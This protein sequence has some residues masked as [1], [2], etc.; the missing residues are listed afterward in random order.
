[1]QRA[2]STA[3]HLRV[4]NAAVLAD[5][6]EQ[7]GSASMTHALDLLLADLRL[8]A[9]LLA[10]CLD[11]G[12]EARARRTGHKLKG[13]MDQ[14][15]IRD[16]DGRATKLSSRYDLYW[17]TECTS[18]FALCQTAIDETRKLQKTRNVSNDDGG[19]GIVRNVG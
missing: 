15:G 7:I 13:I 9:E 11:S 2:G 12:D 18:L 14:Y 4:F 10:S 16:P 5:L 6:E 19:D 17:V 8:C 1:M 3:R